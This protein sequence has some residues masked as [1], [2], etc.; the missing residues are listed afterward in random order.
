MPQT[1]VSVNA[2]AAFAGL[3]G[4][5]GDDAY[6]RSY[7]NGEASAEIPYGV[8]VV[9]DSSEDH[10]A[11]LPTADTDLPCGV[12][13]H[14]HAYAKDNELGTTGL[15]PDVTMSVLQRGRVWVATEDAVDP[16]DAVRIRKVAGGSEQLGAF[17]AAADGTDTMVAT[18]AR[19]LTS[20]SGAGF[21]LLEF[22][23]NGMTLTSD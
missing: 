15:K 4:D 14:S 2:A 18:N 20:T 8:F 11:D 22:D 5:A 6:V 19:W 23:V 1:S 12:V 3:I 7:V 21:A 9:I 10:E 16:G 13:L 17:R